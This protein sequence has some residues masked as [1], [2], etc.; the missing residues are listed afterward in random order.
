LGGKVFGECVK[1]ISRKYRGVT[2]R[3]V[4]G[5]PLTL[6]RLKFILVLFYGIS[7][8]AADMITGN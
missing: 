6:G 4:S 1:V 7:E 5:N 3:K 8:G 2:V